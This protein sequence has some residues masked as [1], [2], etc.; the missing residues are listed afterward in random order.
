MPSRRSGDILTADPSIGVWCRRANGRTRLQSNFPDAAVK[1]RQ[2][3]SEQLYFDG[4][5]SS[6]FAVRPIDFQGHIGVRL[7]RLFSVGRRLLAR[8][9]L[10][11]GWL[12]SPDEG[13]DDAENSS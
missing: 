9:V 10:V 13:K 6:P 4:E 8:R 5:I 3:A 12:S 1:K 7:R 11:L 2:S